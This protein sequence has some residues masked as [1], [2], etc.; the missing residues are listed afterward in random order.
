MGI[1]G[2]TRNII[3]CHLF[4]NNKNIDADGRFIYMLITGI[5]VTEPVADLFM[6]IYHNLT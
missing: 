3:Y 5:D 1:L 6:I 2:S 4:I